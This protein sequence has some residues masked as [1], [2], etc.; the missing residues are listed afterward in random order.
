MKTITFKVT[1]DEARRIRQFARRE[2]LS[3]SAYLRSRAA[4]TPAGST[5]KKVRCR[6]TGAQ[7]FA[8]SPGA[9]PLTTESV[10]EMLA[11]FP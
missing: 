7:I 2:R 6:L 1:D 5:I 9:A 3:L 10:R 8:A 11:D 4:G